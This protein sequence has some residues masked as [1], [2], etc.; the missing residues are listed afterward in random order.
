[1]TT[2]EQV[3][4]TQRMLASLEAIRV[5]ALLVENGEQ[6]Y[7]ITGKEIDL[8]PLREGVGELAAE[9]NFLADKR[10]DFPLLDANFDALKADRKSVV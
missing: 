9:L 3:L 7:L 8:A 1:M 4:R 5:E 2:N 6:S 10:A